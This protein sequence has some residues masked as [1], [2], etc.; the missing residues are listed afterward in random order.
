[1]SVVDSFSRAVRRAVIHHND[2]PVLPSRG[3]QVVNDALQCR[4]QAQA[5]VVSRD[6]DRKRAGS[7]W[8]VQRRLNKPLVGNGPYNKWFSSQELLLSLED[9]LF[10]QRLQRITRDRSPRGSNPMGTNLTLPQPS[11]KSYTIRGKP[12]EVLSVTRR[13]YGGWPYPY[14]PADGKSG[15]CP[16]RPERRASAD[17]REEGRGQRAGLCAVSVARSRRHCRRGRLPV[18]H[19]HW[20]TQ[21]SRGEARL[22]LQ[23][24]ACHAG[25]VAWARRRRDPLPPALPRPDRQPRRSQRVRDARK[26]DQSRSAGSWRLAASSKWKRQ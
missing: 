5:F 14:H 17:L 16:P 21:H 18:P 3:L 10:E 24:S 8:A 7:Q 9:G 11:R 12:A 23:D 25:K 19:Q 26:G 1:M 22:S 4:R 2:L 20:R 15:L 6:N 13:V